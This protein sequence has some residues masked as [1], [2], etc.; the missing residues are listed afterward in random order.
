[1]CIRTAQIP[2]ARWPGHLDFVRWRL[3]CV[4]GRG[5]RSSVHILLRVTLLAPKNFDMDPTIILNKF[6]HLLH[7]YPS[8]LACEAVYQGYW[9]P[10]LRRNIQPPSQGPGSTKK[11]LARAYGSLKMKAVCFSKCW[12]AV[13]LGIK[14]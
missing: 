2:G 6:V 5:G 1:M 12:K 9:Y 10:T 4:W 11:I 13:K 7:K 8:L 3:I 14:T